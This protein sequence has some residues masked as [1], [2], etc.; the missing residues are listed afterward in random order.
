MGHSR[1]YM[2]KKHGEI[3][4]TCVGNGDISLTCD[5]IY[6]GNLWWK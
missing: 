4:S 2:Q 6:E 3:C 1:G 5:D